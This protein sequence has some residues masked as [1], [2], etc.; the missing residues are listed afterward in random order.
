MNWKYDPRPQRVTTEDGELLIADIRGWGRL[1]KSP[2][3]KKIQDYHGRL[4]AAAPELLEMAHRFK[5]Y[6]ELDGA[7]CRCGKTE[8][9]STQLLEL[10][11]K[12]EGEK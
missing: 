2:D 12:V 4:I 5:D 6:I 7:L 3:A 10:I 11:A 8:C 9:K 1:Q